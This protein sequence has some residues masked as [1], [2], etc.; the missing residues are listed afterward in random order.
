MSL[1]GTIR[2]RGSKVTVYH[3]LD[4]EAADQSTVRTYPT[5]TPDVY[6]LL[7]DLTDEQRIRVFGAE[8]QGSMKGLVT[9]RGVV[10]LEGDLVVVT[11]GTHVGETFRIVS[12]LYQQNGTSPHTELL[13]APTTEAYA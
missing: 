13:L 12:K 11:E 2:R 10:L 1:A 4:T 7:E 6:V 8:R 3:G 9:D 5:N